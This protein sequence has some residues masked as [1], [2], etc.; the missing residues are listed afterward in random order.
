MYKIRQIKYAAGSTS[1]QVY[2]IENRKRVIVR[3]IGTAR[4][5]QEKVDL[6]SLANDFIDRIS[7]QP[8]LFAEKDS[9]N[10]LYLNQVEFIGVYHSFFYELIF[11]LIVTIG[12][13]KLKNMLLLDLVI[14]RIFLYCAMRHPSYK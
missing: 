4:S 14:I 12:F 7:K 3:H 8:S 2:K 11:K 10:V 6:L 5:E 9:G 13:D 1:I